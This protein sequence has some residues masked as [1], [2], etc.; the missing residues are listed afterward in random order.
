[1]EKEITLNKPNELITIISK[2]NFD[3]SKKGI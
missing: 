1:M 2:R 3:F